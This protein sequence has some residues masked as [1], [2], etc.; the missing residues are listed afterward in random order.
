M[1]SRRVPSGILGP[2][3]SGVAVVDEIFTF[4]RFSVV[5]RHKINA[6]RLEEAA[7]RGAHGGRLTAG[8]LLIKRPS[9]SAVLGRPKTDAYSRSAA[10][11]RSA[12]S[13]APVDEGVPGRPGFSPEKRYFRNKARN[14][15][16]PLVPSMGESVTPV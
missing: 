16:F 7:D 10:A 1:L 2:R 3:R 12:A 4:C 14:S 8:A 6:A 9:V 5:N 11:E 15:L 13:S